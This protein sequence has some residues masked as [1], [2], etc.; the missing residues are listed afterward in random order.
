MAFSIKGDYIATCDCQLICPCAFDGPP[1]GKDGQCHG[2]AVFA[3]AEGNLDGTDLSGVNVGWLYNAPGNFT[4]GNVRMGMVVDDKASDEQAN[5]I[6]KIFKGEAG[7]VFEQFVP[8]VG[9]WL[10]KERAP[11]SYT[12]G[13]SPSG[14]IG[15]GSLNVELMTGSDGNPTVI[16]NAA[17]AWRAEGY[18]VGRGS[19]SVSAAGISYDA[20]Y[21]EHAEFEF[22]G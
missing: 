16:K 17:M 6:E 21:G 1:T 8:L 13:K 19:G 4:S 2:G 9:E 18:Q 7:G 12:G 20:V 10:G 3:I 5:A 22:T 11:V 14:K 15:K